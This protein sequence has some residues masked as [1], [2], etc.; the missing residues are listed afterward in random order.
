MTRPVWYEDFRAYVPN[1]DIVGATSFFTPVGSVDNGGL[2]NDFGP[3]PGEYAVVS[4]NASGTITYAGD[5]SYYGGA[6]YIAEDSAISGD[7]STIYVCALPDPP[8][9]EDINYELV[10]IHLNSSPT[11]NPNTYYVKGGYY[12]CFRV[13]APAF[14]DVNDWYVTTEV[15]GPPPEPT[16]TLFF[17]NIGGATE[18][19]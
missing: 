14:G 2:S 4:Q 1:P 7:M 3:V 16:D 10:W 11:P 17:T 13:G 19:L 6:F 8:Y 18:T 5:V 15:L 12:Y 9:A